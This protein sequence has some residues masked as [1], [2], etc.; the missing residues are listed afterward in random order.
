MI[1]WIC[2]YRLGPDDT[3]RM[4]RHR[5]NNPRLASLPVRGPYERLMAKGRQR[6]PARRGAWRSGAALGNP[7][8][9]YR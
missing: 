7:R 6:R 2:G 5:V 9:P 3:Y 4:G 8:L 1:D